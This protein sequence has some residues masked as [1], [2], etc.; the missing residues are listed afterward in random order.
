[1]QPAPVP[2][3]NTSRLE[4]LC[5]DFDPAAS[6]HAPT[7]PGAQRS[8]M[9]LLRQ[10]CWRWVRLLG[11]LVPCAPCH[12]GQ[13]PPAPASVRDG[14]A[15]QCV[16]KRHGEMGTLSPH[17]PRLIAAH[18]QRLAPGERPPEASP[19]ALLHACKSAQA[20]RARPGRRATG[21]HAAGM[22]LPP[23]AMA[24]RTTRR[25]PNLPAHSRRA[26][27]VSRR[28]QP[29]VELARAPP[30]CIGGCTLRPR[31]GAV[32]LCLGQACQGA[33]PAGARASISGIAAA[34]PPLPPCCSEAAARPGLGRQHGLCRRQKM[35]SLGW[36]S[37]QTVHGYKQRRT[38]MSYPS[39]S[40]PRPTWRVEGGAP[41]LQR[42]GGHSHVPPGA[43]RVLAGFDR[44][45]APS[46]AQR[47]ISV[48]LIAAHRR[49]SMR[50][51]LPCQHRLSTGTRQRHL[52]WL[53][54][55]GRR[56]DTPLRPGR[57][58]PS[59]PTG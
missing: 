40:A 11:F 17:L 5:R 18:S 13:T 29:R 4:G 52:Y 14:C 37:T 34:A 51:H 22:R 25:A 58:Q 50:A 8:G 32:Q 55:I 54:G 43:P 57:V 31:L 38:A 36:Y 6:G 46:S 24:D 48:S 28:P 2:P 35:S 7:A 3:I 20:P 44:P 45:A 39:P 42:R 27:A 21:V 10:P 49:A 15:E 19:R 59:S 56:W 30:R 9:C 12:A 23:G 41:N 47:C 16:S 26:A 53:V 33:D 1:M